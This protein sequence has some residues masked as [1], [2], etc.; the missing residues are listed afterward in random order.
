MNSQPLATSDTQ[1]PGRW[2]RLAT[3]RLHTECPQEYADGA[4]IALGVVLADIRA[5]VEQWR[6]EAR[7]DVATL[8]TAQAR[9]IEAAIAS[10]YTE[11]LDLL[12]TG[13]SD[14]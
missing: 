9:A 2:L 11:V 5:T 4:R 12:A 3:A 14:D 6:D 8:P 1:V 13:G 10:A 7:L